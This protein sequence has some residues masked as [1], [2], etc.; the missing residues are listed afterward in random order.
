MTTANTNNTTKIRI[1]LAGVGAIVITVLGALMSEIFLPM[2]EGIRDTLYPAPNT[3]ITSARYYDN[4]GLIREVLDNGTIS[5]PGITFG[6]EAV[7]NKT[8]LKVYDEFECSFDGSPYEP[9]ISPKSYDSLGPDTKHVFKVR[10]KGLF[11]NTDNDPD[12]REFIPV[13]SA[14]IEGIIANTNR[15][16]QVGL[17]D[18]KNITTESQ[19][20]LFPTK[21][22]KGATQSEYLHKP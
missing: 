4:N 11:G 5:A 1:I 8:I 22:S 16:V 12:I 14:V 2:S 20:R 6:F 19:G 10:A 21:Y 17:G 3:T 7:P 18:S 9:C 13:T 15:T